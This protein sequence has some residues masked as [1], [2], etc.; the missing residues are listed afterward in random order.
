MPLPD[1]HSASAIAEINPL[2]ADSL[3]CSFVNHRV[4]SLPRVTLAFRPG[5]T[6]TA[7]SLIR[8]TKFIDSI[9][10][11]HHGPSAPEAAKKETPAVPEREEGD[12]TAEEACRSGSPS[13]PPLILIADG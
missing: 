2:A 5:T 8:S 6:R 3:Y 13:D 9:R 7:Y 1:S 11:K 4:D 12:Q 10:R